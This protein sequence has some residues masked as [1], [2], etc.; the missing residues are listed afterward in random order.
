MG[1][2][3][4]RRIASGNEIVDVRLFNRLVGALPPAAVDVPRRTRVVLPQFLQPD[5][6]KTTISWV[7]SAK[8]EETRDYRLTTVITDSANGLQ[9]VILRR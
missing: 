3:T 6:R 8:R 4:L 7:V 2:S 9:I 1:R 5:Y